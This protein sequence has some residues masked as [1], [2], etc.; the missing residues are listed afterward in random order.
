M[1]IKSLSQ[2]VLNLIAS[3]RKLDIAGT[4]TICPYYI[5]TH[6]RRAELRSLIG[7]GLPDEI[8]LE[9]LVYAK[10]R[11]INLS[12][13]SNEE[14]RQFMI[15]E[16]IGIDCSGYISH[17][18]NA[19]LNG[20]TLRNILKFKDNSLKM[21]L[22]RLIR[23]IENISADELT[24]NLNTTIIDIKDIQIG[25]LI[26]FNYNQKGFHVALIF[27][28]GFENNKLS[29]FKYTHSSAKYENE[30]GVRIGV[31]N[32]INTESPLE[33]QNWNDEYNGINY[34][35]DEYIKHKSDSGFRRLKLLH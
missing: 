35:K 29:Y 22:L 26:R 5:N 4:K 28:C 31:V 1:E 2:N 10:M 9:V 27:E 32:I 17:L 20:R 19:E 30:N 33:E 6:K 3:Y 21:R 8:E 25:D 11:K 7:K 34:L 18:L 12:L 23:F 14:I 16:G 15:K 13:L 24:S